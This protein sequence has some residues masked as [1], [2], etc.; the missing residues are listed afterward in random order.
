MRVRSA[1]DLATALKSRKSKKV[2][3]I[4]NNV[5]W[6]DSPNCPQQRWRWKAVERSCREESLAES[7]AEVHGLERLYTNKGRAAAIQ[8]SKGSVEHKFTTERTHKNRA[9]W[10][11]TMADL[12]QKCWPPNRR[13]WSPNRR[14][15]PRGGRRLSFYSL[16]PSLE[17]FSCFCRHAA[18]TNCWL[19][20]KVLENDVIRSDSLHAGNVKRKAVWRT[21]QELQSYNV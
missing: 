4:C 12:K 18:G 14:C 10:R 11:P 9:H 1:N 8:T 16:S 2:I 7:L 3:L 19:F 6:G 21:L 20:E 17:T 5:Q 13:C 15:W